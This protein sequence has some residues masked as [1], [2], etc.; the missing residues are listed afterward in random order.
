[1]GVLAADTLQGP[2]IDWFALSPLLVLL[3]GTMVLLVVG[4]PCHSA[5][6]SK[7]VENQQPP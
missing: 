2:E 1:M 7:S 4:A 6:A 5:P 3:G